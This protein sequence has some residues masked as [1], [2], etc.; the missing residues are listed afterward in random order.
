MMRLHV[1]GS[2][3]SFLLPHKPEMLLCQYLRLVIM[4]TLVKHDDLL[5][6]RAHWARCDGDDDGDDRTVRGLLFYMTCEDSKQIRFNYANRLLK[7][8]SLT[9]SSIYGVVENTMGRELHGNASMIDV[10]SKCAICLKPGVNYR[11]SCGDTFHRR[12]LA[13]NRELKCWVC[14]KPFD[15]RDALMRNRYRRLYL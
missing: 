13:C 6:Y 10:R 3:A 7:M 8:G 15:F 14:R 1:M 2:Q 11:L 5:F 4:R 9:T 12:C